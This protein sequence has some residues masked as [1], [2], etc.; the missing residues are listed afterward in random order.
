MNLYWQQLL[1]LL[2]K[3]PAAFWGVVVGSFFSLSGVY[4]TNRAS[5]KRVNLQF[6]NDRESRKHDR[7]MELRKGIFLDAAAAISASVNV[8]SKFSQLTIPNEDLSETFLGASPALAKVN[9]VASEETIRA[10][11]VFYTEFGSA[12]FRL[13]ERRIPLLVLQN[14]INQR[15]ILCKDFEQTRD[16]MLEQMRHYNIEG[17][18]DAR[19]FEAIKGNFDFEAQRIAEVSEDIKRLTLDFATKNMIYAKE[20]F[21]ENTKVNRSVIPVL[22]AARKELEFSGSQDAFT[23]ILYS[24][25]AQANA[26]LDSF[27][28]QVSATMQNPSGNL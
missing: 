22:V 4:L 18:Q 5:E 23:E 13:L 21:A 20:C 8:L 25:H 16:A 12:F 2:G 17:V 24:A 3:V 10:L 15:T 14:E 28:Q 26:Q 1:I 19:K 7:E 27:L 9:L 11:S 6:R